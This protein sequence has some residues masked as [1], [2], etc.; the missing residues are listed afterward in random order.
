M[1]PA[2]FAAIFPEFSDIPMESVQ[3]QIDMAQPYFNAARW[4]S[5]LSEGMGNLIA[6]QLA[7]SAQNSSSNGLSSDA[8]KK[9]VGDVE[10]MN[11]DAMLLKKAENP[12]MRTLYGQRYLYLMK[13]IGAGVIV[14]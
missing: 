13:L 14:V 6:H 4:G 3:K 2:E 9:R 1:T 11:S 7:L 10:V 12:Y 8:T 5:F